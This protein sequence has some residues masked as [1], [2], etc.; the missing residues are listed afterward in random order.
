MV[1]CAIN[2][3]Q[4]ILLFP[5]KLKPVEKIVYDVDCRVAVIDFNSLSKPI[6]ELLGSFTEQVN[7]QTRTCQYFLLLLLQLYAS[8]VQMNDVLI[9]ISSI[10][11][12]P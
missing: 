1:C 10:P 6:N 11:Q 2:P 4:P 3:A 7:P 8:F 9:V 5:V 12:L